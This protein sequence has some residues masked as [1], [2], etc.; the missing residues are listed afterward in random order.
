MCFQVYLGS[1]HEC[2]EIEY[3][4]H[5]EHIFMHRLH[6]GYASVLHLKGPC[7]CHTGVR[8][9][10]CGLPEGF[11]VSQQDE[12]TQKHPR[13]LGEYVGQ[14]LEN[15]EP[16]EFFRCWNGDETLPVEKHRWITLEDFLAPEFYFNERQL[17][18]V[19]KD[20][21]SL[22]AVKDG[23]RPVDLDG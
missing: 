17:T 10:G 12:W 22:Q 23:I 21:N 15:A 19:C 3:S 1:S 13:Q 2:T 4:E 8:D 11:P 20:Q 5:W 14:C 6:S 9:C 16:V 18:V 7:V